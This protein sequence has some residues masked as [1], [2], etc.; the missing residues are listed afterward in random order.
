M[1]GEY[2]LHYTDDLSKI[3]LQ[4]NPRTVDRSSSSLVLVGRGVPNFG[5]EAQE[6]LLHMLENHCSPISPTNPTEGQLWY[7]AGHQLLKI[8][9]GFETYESSHTFNKADPNDSA[10]VRDIN[11]LRI[12]IWVVIGGGSNGQGNKFISP[13]APTSG[14]DGDIWY[15]I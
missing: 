12:P 14:E 10:Y 4:I 1:A 15:Q 11:G 2:I 7:D 13:T 8:C 5:D 9:A 6:N 3:P